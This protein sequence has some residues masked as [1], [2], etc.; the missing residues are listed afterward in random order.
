V[1]FNARQAVQT[2]AKQRL[3]QGK[4]RLR[5]GKER[6]RQ[7]KERLRQ[8]KER[9]R[10]GKERREGKEAHATTDPHGVQ[11]EYWIDA[12]NCLP[13]S[14]QSGSSVACLAHIKGSRPYQ[15]IVATSRV[16]GTSR[17]DCRITRGWLGRVAVLPGSL[18]PIR[19][20][21]ITSLLHAAA[22]CK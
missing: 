12:T 19:Y 11:V 3:R 7:G 21:H 2:V 4:E 1:R 8:G 13:I 17:R 14:S 9:L 6:L 18:P 20:V 15:E 10:Q 5:Q 16:A 22:N